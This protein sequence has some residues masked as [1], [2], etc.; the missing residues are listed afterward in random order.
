MQVD[1]QVPKLCIASHARSPSVGARG[2]YS[3]LITSFSQGE[4]VWIGHF[5]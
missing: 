5:K 1:F 4:R 2:V 3:F